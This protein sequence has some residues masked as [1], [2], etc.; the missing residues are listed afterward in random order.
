MAKCVSC[1][2]GLAIGFDVAVFFTHSELFERIPNGEEFLWW[3]LLRLLKINCQML[4]CAFKYTFSIKSTSEVNYR[5]IIKSLKVQFLIDVMWSAALSKYPRSNGADGFFLYPS[6]QYPPVLT[7]FRENPKE[8][9]LF[10][11]TSHA[12][13]GWT[14]QLNRFSDLINPSYGPILNPHAL[15]VRILP[16]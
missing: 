11:R 8:M 5:P 2:V 3:F 4:N 14:L 15:F 7:D 10:S 16:H 6:D 9:R 1:E 13:F 12:I